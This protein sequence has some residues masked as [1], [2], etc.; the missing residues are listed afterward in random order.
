MAEVGRK[1]QCS[2]LEYLVQTSPW[3]QSQLATMKL[4]WRL[5]QKLDDFHWSG[6]EVKVSAPE[7]TEKSSLQLHGLA[8]EYFSNWPE[9]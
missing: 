3:A 5:K 7:E 8:C 2:K 4:S 9:Q 6:F 1:Q